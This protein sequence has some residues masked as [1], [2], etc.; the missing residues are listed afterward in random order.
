MATLTGQFVSIGEGATYQ[1]TIT[2]DSIPAAGTLNLSADPLHIIMPQSDDKYPGVR[3]LE[4]EINVL[5][6]DSLAYLYS[7][8]PLHTTVTI[9]RNT[10]TIFSGYLEPSQWQQPMTPGEWNEVQVVAIDTLA[11]LKNVPFYDRTL[12]RGTPDDYGTPSLISMLKEHCGSDITVSYQSGLSSVLDG[13]FS[14]EAFIGTDISDTTA[15]TF[16]G[17]MLSD[18]ARAMGITLMMRGRTLYVYKQDSEPTNTG[19]DLQDHLAS[20][21]LDMEIVPPVREVTGKWD[22]EP[23]VEKPEGSGMSYNTYDYGTDPRTVPTA[24]RGNWEVYNWP[25]SFS[26]WSTQHRP[27]LFGTATDR[28][29]SSGTPTLFPGIG[30]REVA[31]KVHVRVPYV[32][33]QWSVKC[34]THMNYNRGTSAYANKRMALLPDDYNE[35]TWDESS[36]VLRSTIFL[37]IGD[38]VLDPYQVRSYA[39]QSDDDIHEQKWAEYIFRFPFSDISNEMLISNHG[40][41]CIGVRSTYPDNT[42]ELTPHFA[43][44]FSFFW[45]MTT[46]NE[47]TKSINNSPLL[48]SKGIDT[49]LYKGNNSGCILGSIGF[50]D[51]VAAG[52]DSAIDTIANQY[53]VAHTQW[54]G[55]FTASIVSSSFT[56]SITH[57]HKLLGKSHSVQA[58]DWDVRNNELSLTLLEDYVN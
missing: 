36:N 58:C 16:V 40:K 20:N 49:A 43:K 6:K 42:R 55:D 3:T 30:A 39:Y 41:L 21:N 15:H 14:S 29:T 35:D 12:L 33:G 4:A 10:T 9:K 23:E 11:A 8:D 28:S 50:K 32:H 26:A 18:Y 1:I 5:T 45:E 44:D 56:T 27:C 7:D 37:T 13:Y 31:D 22:D 57:H 17:D 46:G 34:L 38:T 54:T 24:T 52:T 53:R 51:Y 19:Y 2:S 47:I 25:S 48:D